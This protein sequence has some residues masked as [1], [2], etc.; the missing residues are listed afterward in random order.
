MID[1][2]EAIN[3]DN[4][5]A[6]M[7]R[8]RLRAQRQIL[9]LR[10]L[11]ASM[12]A[13]NTQG[14]AIDHSE[15]DR[16]L[17][18]QMRLARAEREF[19]LTDPE[20]SS[21]EEPICDADAAFNTDSRWGA[22]KEIFGLSSAEVD[23]LS[24]CV[25]A[26]RDPGMVRICGYL[27]DNAAACYPTV[28][29]AASLFSWQAG[30]SIDAGSPLV[31]WRLAG[32]RDSSTTPWSLSLPWSVDPF[33]AAWVNGESAVDPILASAVEGPDDEE[34]QDECLYAAE[35]DSLVA[36]IEQMTAPEGRQETVAIEL[37]GPD[38]TG[39]RT[40]ARQIAKGVQSQIV[41]A[42]AGVLCRSEEVAFPLACLRAT[43]AV[44]LALLSGSILYWS[45]PEAADKRLWQS[46]PGQA[47][48]TIFG[49]ES[50][51][52]R[53]GRNNAAWRTLRM[54]QL[55]R[56]AR[57]GLW[58][59]LTKEDPPLQI[60]EW[61][62]TPQEIADAARVSAAGHDAVIDACRKSLHS[63]KGDMVAPLICPYEWSDIVLP[64]AVA[65]HIKEVE[66]QARLRW[67]VY[68]EWN[69][70]RLC[71][72]GRGISAMFAGPSGT[73]KTM[74]AQVIA[75]SLGMDLY[76]VD[77]AGVMSKYI[78]ETEKNLKQIFDSCERANVLLFFDEADALFGQ[79]T[80][81]KD[82]HDRF[83]NIEIDYLLQ[84]MEQFDGLAILATN[85]KADLDD[86]FLR[87][88]RF[89][90]DFLMPGVEERRILW[91]L[92]LHGRGVTE[93][94]NVGDIDWEF[95]AANLTMTGADIKMS[96]LNAAFLARSEGSQIEMR[97]ILHAA[98]RE[99][100]KHGIVLRM[101][102]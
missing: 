74:A 71:P 12:P 88:I 23:L 96:A 85:R 81:V 70:G 62:L 13:G 76:R 44:R 32:Q 101:D 50:T 91:R 40:L 45:N 52:T 30:R 35:R 42:D 82:A 60:A 72:V 47:A 94:Q 63:D 55:D 34:S 66:N 41:C 61:L 1:D 7:S 10:R 54:P 48:T 90:I 14:L 57:T 84:R 6:S 16:L 46:L 3:P 56:A 78:G 87:R 11:W 59:S 80:K 43:H 33:I 38:G 49:S 19:Y 21:Y 99:M 53:S 64:D 9:W 2:Y 18:D 5:R 4:E 86:A 75:R 27:Q 22:L 65:A 26:E 89:I 73:G 29:L 37:I 17:V 97:H 95:L 28:S 79:R 77:L 69:F 102:R 20:A 31:Q 24:L 39:K 68:E 58:S 100:T 93:P 51:M 25:A 83:A 67:E 15:V 8:I 98:R 92:A 36:F